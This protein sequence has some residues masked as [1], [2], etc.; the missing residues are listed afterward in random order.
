MSEYIT[1]L[2]RYDE[3]QLSLAESIVVA[4]MDDLHGR[5]GGL[6]FDDDIISDD[7]GP[8]WKAIIEKRLRSNE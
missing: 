5:G 8:A 3:G 6:E 1:G 2:L 7:I 4:I